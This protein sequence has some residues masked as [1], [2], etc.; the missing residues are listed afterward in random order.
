MAIAN[1]TKA[2]ELRADNP[3]F[4]GNLVRARIKN[5]ETGTEIQALLEQLLTCDIRPE[6]IVWAKEKLVLMKNQ[7]GSGDDLGQ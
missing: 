2:V 1:Y 3:E 6:W 7:S 4:I 5:G